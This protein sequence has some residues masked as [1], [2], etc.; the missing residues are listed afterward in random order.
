MT[1]LKKKESPQSGSNKE[2]VKIGVGTSRVFI[3][4]GE[5]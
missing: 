3:A 1:S 4:F 2:R 5:K